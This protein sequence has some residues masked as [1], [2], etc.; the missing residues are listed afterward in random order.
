MPGF[1]L[2]LDGQEL[3]HL[4]VMG[5]HAADESGRHLEC[6]LFVLDEVR[7]DLD[8][9]LLDLVRELDRRSPVDGHLRVPLHGDGLRVQLGSEVGPELR[10]EFQVGTYQGE[11][12]FFDQGPARR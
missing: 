6:R 1:V 12:T 9:R 5:M 8:D 3:D 11:S 10:L 7:H 4:A 2:R